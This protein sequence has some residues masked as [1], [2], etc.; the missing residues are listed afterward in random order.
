MRALINLY[1]TVSRVEA[2]VRVGRRVLCTELTASF[3]GF[4]R[5][6]AALNNAFRMLETPTYTRRPRGG[7]AQPPR[8]SANE[9]VRG[10]SVDLRFITPV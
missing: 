7:L 4:L 8:Y 5:H 10:M 2:R 9:V 6:S 1:A 3:G